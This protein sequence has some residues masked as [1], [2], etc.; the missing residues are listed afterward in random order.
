MADIK[1]T[2]TTV[3]YDWLQ[4]TDG[5][6]DTVIQFYAVMDICRSQDKPAPDTPCLRFDATTLMITAPDIVWIRSVY[7]D[8]AV[9]CIW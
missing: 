3:G 1:T 5:S 6:V 8:T 4:I 2:Q 7:V 9:V